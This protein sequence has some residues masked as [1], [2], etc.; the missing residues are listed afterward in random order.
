MLY[1][2]VAGQ[3]LLCHG[4]GRGLTAKVG[5]FGMSRMLEGEEDACV[6]ERT[7]TTNVFG[8]LAYCAPELLTSATPPQ[9]SEQSPERCIKRA[10][11][12]DVRL[13]PP[14]CSVYVSV[15]C[16]H[17]VPS[18]CTGLLVWCDRLGGGG[19]VHPF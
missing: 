11:K 15:A 7:L 10:L 3:S 9:T 13:V 5:D 1:A 4:A 8:T 16:L 2:A 19:A 18:S 17:V 12:A 6:L 14:G